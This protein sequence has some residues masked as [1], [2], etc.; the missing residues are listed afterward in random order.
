MTE[1]MEETEL[2]T[3]ADSARAIMEDGRKVRLPN[4][5]GLVLPVV[6]LE[7]WTRCAVCSVQTFKLR[8]FRPCI[9]E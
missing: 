6:R 1:E 8:L 3:L 4:S 2:Q 7:Y 5:A 9:S